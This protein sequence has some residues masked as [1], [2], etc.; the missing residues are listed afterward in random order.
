MHIIA[1]GGMSCYNPSNTMD[2][3]LLTIN[4]SYVDGIKLDVFKSKDHYF[5]LSTDDDLSKST[6]SKKKI[7]ETNYEYLK[8]VKFPSH[9]FKYYLPT[10]KEVLDKYIIKKKLILCL[11]ILDNENLFL[12]K[13]YD[14]LAQYN[15]EYYFITDRDFF[16][17]HPISKLGKVLSDNDYYYVNDNLDLLGDIDKDTLIITKNP[18]K[19][20]HYFH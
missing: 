18:V 5:V 4:L 19:I 20:Y 11:H 10:L 2:A 6:L 8:K 15:Y 14:L 12:D 3:I 16:L 7:H 17:F 9:I 13:L 1:D